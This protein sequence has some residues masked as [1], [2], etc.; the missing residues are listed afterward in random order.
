MSNNV[1]FKK[2]LDNPYYCVTTVVCPGFLK[3]MLNDDFRTLF[4]LL[5]ALNSEAMFNRKL[6]NGN[7]SLMKS[8]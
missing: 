3:Q 6:R 7:E 8:Q 2:N 5:C 4:G 1:C